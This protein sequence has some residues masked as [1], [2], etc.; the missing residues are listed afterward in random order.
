MCWQKEGNWGRLV[1][2]RC[3]TTYP[4]ITYLVRAKDT[5]EQMKWIVQ[6]LE[7]KRLRYCELTA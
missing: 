4:L 2:G 1:G 3:A 5:I 6:R 7:G